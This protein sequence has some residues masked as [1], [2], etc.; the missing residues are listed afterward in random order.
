MD[1]IN[2]HKN[3]PPHVRSNPWPEITPLFK[4]WVREQKTNPNSK[5]QMESKWWEQTNQKKNEGLYV[6]F[7]NG[8]W[9]DPGNITS[10]QFEYSFNYI[11]F[12]LE[13]LESY[14]SIPSEFYTNSLPD[15]IDKMKEG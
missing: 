4:K 7:K 11:R 12:L 14:H 8:E 5:I 13:Y 10:E 6:D 15:L 9:E 2:N 1:W 3:N